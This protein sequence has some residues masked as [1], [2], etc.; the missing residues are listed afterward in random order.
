MFSHS[1]QRNIDSDGDF[2]KRD[3]GLDT[4]DFFK[5]LITKK[6][7]KEEKLKDLDPNQ[8]KDMIKSISAQKYFMMPLEIK[9]LK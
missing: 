8:K 7:E 6:N 9:Q 5:S 1:P 4:T 2:I 3:V